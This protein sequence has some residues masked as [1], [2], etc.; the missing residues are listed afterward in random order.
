MEMLIY[1]YSTVNES[2]SPVL[3]TQKESTKTGHFDS[4]RNNQCFLKSGSDE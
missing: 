3:L 4:I 2:M 1:E